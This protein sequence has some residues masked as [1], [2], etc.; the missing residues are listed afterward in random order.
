MSFKV[1]EHN[2]ILT[3]SPPERLGDGESL[4][5]YVI[6]YSI[7][8]SDEV[9]EIVVADNNCELTDLAMG[10]VYMISAK[11]RKDFFFRKKLR[12]ISTDCNHSWYEQVFHRELAGNKI[13]RN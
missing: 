9:K 13:H 3:W 12:I 11:V 10:S 8:G 4:I 6:I 2:A 5:H 1:Y 7:E